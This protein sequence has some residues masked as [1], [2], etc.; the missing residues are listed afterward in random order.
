MGHHVVLHRRLQPRRD[1]SLEPLPPILPRRTTALRSARSDPHACSHAAFGMHPSATT[2]ASRVSTFSSTSMTEGMVDDGLGDDAKAERR[3]GRRSSFPGQHGSNDGRGCRRGESGARGAAAFAADSTIGFVPAPVARPSRQVQH[4]Q[5]PP[6]KR[7]VCVFPHPAA[8]APGVCKYRV[9]TVLD[10]APRGGRE[11]TAMG[12]STAPAARAAACRRLVL[13]ASTTNDD[14][15]EVVVMG[16]RISGRGDAGRAAS[17]YRHEHRRTPRP[18]PSQSPRLW[19][20][21]V[22]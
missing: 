15:N 4:R 22:T 1:E 20:E 2:P 13:V 5:Q 6:C 21:N 7:D 8:A 10:E 16:E 9:G 18:P 14:D 19:A 17:E 12:A 3:R 11:A